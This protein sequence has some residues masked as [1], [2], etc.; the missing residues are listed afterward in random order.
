MMIIVSCDNQQSKNNSFQDNQDNQEIKESINDFNPACEE[1]LLF[2]QAYESA[3]KY[4]KSNLDKGKFNGKFKE[5]LDSC[6]LEMEVEIDYGKLFSTTQKHLIIRRKL[7]WETRIE[8]F[9]KKKKNYQV[10]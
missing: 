8:I 7:Q 1:E 10:Y 2:K 9:S 4:S 3:L 5:F 6:V